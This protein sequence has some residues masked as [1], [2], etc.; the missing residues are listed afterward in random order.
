VS[1]EEKGLVALTRLDNRVIYDGTID[2][3]LRIAEQSVTALEGTSMADEI[4]A[5]RCALLVS[6][7]LLGLE[8]REP[9]FLRGFRAFGGLVFCLLEGDGDGCAE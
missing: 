1:D 3:G 4:A 7:N 9:L 8:S 6:P 5:R 2:E